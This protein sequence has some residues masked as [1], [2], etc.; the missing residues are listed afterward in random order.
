M[1]AVVVVP[2]PSTGGKRVPA[3]VAAVGRG[4]KSKGAGQHQGGGVRPRNAMIV[5]GVV[6]IFSG[7]VIGQMW[8]DTFI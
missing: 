6:A 2:E 1:T 4:G 3:L 8:A 5:I 7:I